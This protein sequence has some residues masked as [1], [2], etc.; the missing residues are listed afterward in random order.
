MDPLIRPFLSC[1]EGQAD[2]E[3][4]TAWR[5]FQDDDDRWEMRWQKEGEPLSRS[6]RKRMRYPDP[7]NNSGTDRP[8]WFSPGRFWIEPEPDLPCIEIVDNIIH[9]VREAYEAAS[10]GYRKNAAYEIH[11]GIKGPARSDAERVCDR[12]CPLLPR[13]P[14][15]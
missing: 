9:E 15:K 1:A 6:A 14:N 8:G 12:C 5:Y 4:K 11:P 7:G 10:S 2:P 3:F 13:G